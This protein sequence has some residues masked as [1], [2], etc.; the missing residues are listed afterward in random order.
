MSKCMS[1]TYAMQQ[2][3]WKDLEEPYLVRDAAY[4]RHMIKHAFYVDKTTT[5]TR[6]MSFQFT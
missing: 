4:K 6:K 2:Q 3:I 1:I 5:A